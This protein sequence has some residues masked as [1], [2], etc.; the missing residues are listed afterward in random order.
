MLTITSPYT[1][2]LNINLYRRVFFFQTQAQQVQR[3]IVYRARLCIRHTQNS[4]IDYSDSC[5]VTGFVCDNCCRLSLWTDGVQRTLHCS[6]KRRAE[7]DH[8]RRRKG[9]C[10]HTD[11][12]SMCGLH[13]GNICCYESLVCTAVVKV[14]RQLRCTQCEGVYSHCMLILLQ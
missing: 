12:W 7:L 6:S 2:V 5:L 14:F 9:T 8:L 13:A 4:L 1:L 11:Y 10:F 3:S